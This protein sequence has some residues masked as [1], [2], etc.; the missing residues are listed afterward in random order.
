VK[1]APWSRRWRTIAILLSASAYCLA[2]PPWNISVIAWIALVPLLLAL[3]GIGAWMG[4][5]GGL[6]WGTAVLSGIGYWVPGALARYWQQP[7]WFG[8]FFALGVAVVFMGLY[9]AVFGLAYGRLCARWGAWSRPWLV[10]ALY[11]ACEFARAHLLTGHPWLLLGYALVPHPAL[12]QMADLGSVY[13]LSFALALGNAFLAEFSSQGAVPW[14][15]RARPLAAAA[16][17]VATLWAYGTF[18]LATPLPDAPRIPVLVVQSNLDIGTAWRRESFALGLDRYIELSKDAADRMHPR[19]IVWPESAITFFLEDEPVYQSA[20]ARLVA[21]ENTDLIVGG[22]SRDGESRFFN[23]AF[24]IPAD[25]RVAGRYDKVHL[26]PFAEYFPLRTIEFLR[27]RFERVRYFSP[28]GQP[29]LLHTRFGDVA[30]LICFEAIFP[31][32]VRRE[33]AAGATL[34]VNLSNDGWFGRSAGAEQHLLMVTL[35]AVE[36]RLW[37]V[38]AT[39]TGI[40]AIIDPYGRITTR[41]PLFEAATIDGRIVPMQVATLYERVGDLWAWLCVLACAVGL[42]KKAP[43]AAP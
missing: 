2:F 39:A 34:L 16:A 35:R 19:L 30:T 36:S 28:A 6:L 4:A 24:Y 21:A 23:S 9:F 40:S 41:T 33:T 17:V 42:L 14:T 22:P 29:A 26:L 1:N 20:I 18:R 15:V 38:R 10:A 43:D 27:R 8:F 37:V 3:R 32:V 31:E 11:V 25:G 13:V 5:A 12:M 7:Y